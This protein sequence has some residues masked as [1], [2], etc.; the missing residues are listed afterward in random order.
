M[1]EIQGRI[2]IGTLNKIVYI[3]CPTIMELLSS[4]DGFFIFIF[5]FSFTS[6]K[7]AEQSSTRE[8]TGVIIVQ[9]LLRQKALIKP[10]GLQE[11]HQ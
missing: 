9:L 4:F 1:K 5:I 10:Q 7:N 8:A 3:S 11:V 2:A 6:V